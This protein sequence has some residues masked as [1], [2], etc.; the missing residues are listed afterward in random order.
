MIFSKL[1]IGKSLDI[2]HLPC[3][4]FLRPLASKPRASGRSESWAIRCWLQKVK[5]STDSAT[6]ARRDWAVQEKKRLLS[7]K[8]RLE[9]ELQYVDKCLDCLSLSMQCKVIVDPTTPNTSDGNATNTVEEEKN[10]ESVDFEKELDIEKYDEARDQA[11]LADMFDNCYHSSERFDEDNHLAVAYWTDGLSIER[12]LRDGK[13]FY[14]V[15]D[16]W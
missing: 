6:N 9:T 10:G 3:H 7:R 13:F 2:R 15:T 12:T 5:P 1:V 11:F 4:M 8:T 14:K 16:G